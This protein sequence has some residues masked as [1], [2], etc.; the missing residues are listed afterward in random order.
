MVRDSGC[1]VRVGTTGCTTVALAAFEV[2]L[3]L[4]LLTMTLNV[5]PLSLVCS[6]GVLYA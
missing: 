4:A 2:T 3:P 5:A 6:G 1:E